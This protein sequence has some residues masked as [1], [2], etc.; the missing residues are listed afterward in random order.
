[1]H[2]CN[3]WLERRKALAYVLN[4]IQAILESSQFLDSTKGKKKVQGVPQ[5]QATALLR[6]EEEEEIDKTKQAQIKQTYE[7][8]WA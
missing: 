3:C 7:K 4:I 6:Y 2:R 5:L 8:H 1:M